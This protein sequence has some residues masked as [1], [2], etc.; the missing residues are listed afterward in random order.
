MARL[1]SPKRLTL[2]PDDFHRYAVWVWDDDTEAHLPVSEEDPAPADYG[3]LFIKAR[4][5]SADRHFD[6]YLV[7]GSS[8]YAFGV[9]LA[10]REFVMNLNLPDMMRDN[11]KE[12]YRI[13]DCESF[14]FFPVHYISRVRWKDGK[15]IEGTLAP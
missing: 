7:G 5:N 6:G 4:F 2:T 12:I 11:L 14:D 8:F 10:G 3:T 15:K 1:D 9:F 13:L